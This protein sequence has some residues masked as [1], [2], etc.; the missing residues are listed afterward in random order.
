L[1]SLAG[2]LGDR[3]LENYLREYWSYLK[4]DYFS[5]KKKRGRRS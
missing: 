5:N 4:M 1:V 3:E 2:S